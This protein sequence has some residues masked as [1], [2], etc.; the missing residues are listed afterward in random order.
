[1]SSFANIFRAS[2]IVGA[3][4][5]LMAGSIGLAPARADST[6]KTV[7]S[8]AEMLTAGKFKA[9]RNRDM[10]V[11]NVERKG[12]TVQIILVALDDQIRFIGP[13]ATA[14]RVVKSPKLGGVLLD[15]NAKLP[16]FKV[17]YDAGGNLVL[18]YDIFEK[19]VDADGVKQL[20]FDMAD[21]VIDFHKSADFIKK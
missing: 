2:W 10:F 7:A 8:I 11:M 15:A 1:M 4:A 12:G 18:L 21:S 5:L 9:T 3:L 14:D 13:V 16:V 19:M 20:V 6:D 17:V